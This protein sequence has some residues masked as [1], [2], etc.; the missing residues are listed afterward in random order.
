[1][2]LVACFLVTIF[3]ALVLGEVGSWL[4]TFCFCFFPQ[5]GG[6]EIKLSDLLALALL[7]LFSMIPSNATT[8]VATTSATIWVDVLAA[9][10]VVA[11]AVAVAVP[12]TLATSLTDPE[13]DTSCHMLPAGASGWLLPLILCWITAIPHGFALSFKVCQKEMSQ[14]T[15]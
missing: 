4:S 12:L 15:G 9:A 13:L 1:M 8:V 14:A 3:N 5:C 2:V 7:P 6:D 10:M 11:L